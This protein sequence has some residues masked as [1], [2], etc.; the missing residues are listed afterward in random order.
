M[1]PPR[2]ATP[3]GMSRWLWGCE[4]SAST[5]A[6]INQQGKVM[7]RCTLMRAAAEL[8]KGGVGVPLGP[9]PQRLAVSPLPGAPRAP[10]PVPLTCHCPGVALLHAVPGVI[11]Q[12]RPRPLRWGPWQG[13]DGVSGVAGAGTAG[14]HGPSPQSGAAVGPG[15][16]PKPWGRDG[17]TPPG[18]GGAVGQSPILF[19]DNH[20]A[21]G[22]CTDLGDWAPPGTR[23]SRCSP[24]P[25]R[26]HQRRR[27]RLCRG[28]K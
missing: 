1:P 24:T 12:L 26:R 28:L 15:D 19:G 8:G 20:R 27:P 3:P 21:R 5:A 7:L 17:A 2:P 18:H 6:G 23:A 4:L 16:T 13:E 11:R 22:V 10:A 9:Q 14:S 25:R